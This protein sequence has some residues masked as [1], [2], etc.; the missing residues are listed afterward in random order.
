MKTSD[1]IVKFLE[2][3]KVTHVFELCGGAIT[4]LLDSLSKSKRI[5][6]VS[7]HHEQA[8]AFAAEGYSRTATDGIGVA[9]ATSGPGATNLITGIASCFFD[10][11]PCVFIT[12][13]VNTNEYKF[14]KPIRQLGF[15]ETDIVSIV[16]PIV[17]DAVLVEKPEKIR[18]YL[19][20]AFFIARS[21]R[22]GPVLIDLP[23]N[24]QRA[25]IRTRSLKGFRPSSSSEVDERISD[26]TIAKSINLLRSAKR[27][28]ILTGGGVRASRAQE[29]L[30]ELA[31]K[32]GIP[33]VSS[34]LGLDSFPHDDASFVGMIGTYGNRYANLAIADADLIL[35]LGTRFDSR[36]VGTKPETFAREA[37]IIHVDIDRHELNN[38][39][40]VKLPVKA[41]IK[42][43][44]SILNKKLNEFD[45][46]QILPWKNKISAL[47]RKFR[48]FQMSAGSGIKPNY[49][50]H[51]LSKHL[52]PN[53]IVSVDVGQNQMWAAQSME[54]TRSQRFI[55]Q[56]GMGAMGSA[57]SMGIGASFA[58][59]NKI[60]VVVTGDGGFQLNAQ[61]LE[62]VHHYRLPIK[63]IMLNNQCYG[64]VRQFQ[65][66][67]FNSKFQ[68]TVIG[69]SSPDFQKIVSAYKIPARKIVSSAEISRSFKRLF[70]DR[71]PMFIE[72]PIAQDVA[73]LPKLSVNKPIEDQDPRLSRKELKSIM[74]TAIILE[75]KK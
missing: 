3:Q 8:A 11:I 31:N 21:G 27:P 62:T 69:Y 66:Q 7:M 26:K 42:R 34:L 51:V 64:M 19:E 6:I 45:R 67:Y 75:D 50:M 36:Q 71:K 72:V 44:L 73:V 35:A 53:S 48:S 57:L 12:G 18:Y 15:Q 13:Q 5:K 23:M 1:Y 25:D 74:N 55:T 49:L 2:K 10:S 54:I 32:T 22:P 4:H 68:S 30:I 46:Q 29:E 38:K 20:R 37:K 59:P 47:K 61:E 43:F 60:I 40:K 9:T 58:N 14:N 65:K 52:P 39:I 33:V 17:K 24:V 56:G 16:K 41:D 70:Y 63:I 28:I